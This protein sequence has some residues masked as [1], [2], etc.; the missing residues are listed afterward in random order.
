MVKAKKFWNM[1]KADKTGEIYIYG[2][3][4]SYK[5]DD[6][7]VTA[8]SFKD[9]LDALDDIDTLNIYINSAGGSVFQGQAI[10]SILKRHKAHK[11]VYIDGIAASIASVIAMAGDA[12]FMPKNAMMMI[13]RPWTIA[14]GNVDD[15]LAAAEA[16]EK[17]GIAIKAIY[18]ERF[19]QGEDKLQE[20]LDA[21]TWL[22]ADECLEYGLCD[23]VTGEKQIAAYLNSEVLSKYRNVPDFLKSAVGG[24]DLEERQ[25]RAAIAEQSQKNIENLKKILGGL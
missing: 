2:D 16:L 6:S 8:K 11:N 24:D 10:Y 1:K 14:I 18:M 7:D 15:M 13:H 22:T 23:E 25:R 5:W 9:D 19:N 12:I 20:L 21:E 4:V 3:I 17:I